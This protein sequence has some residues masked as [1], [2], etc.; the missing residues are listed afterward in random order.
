MEY[1]DLYLEKYMG[2]LRFANNFQYLYILY[3]TTVVDDFLTIEET[4]WI[5]QNE[6]VIEKKNQLSTS[7]SKIRFAIDLPE[8]IRTKLQLPSGPSIPITWI[9]GDSLSHIDVGERIFSETVLVYVAGSANEGT[10]VLGDDRYE[11]K[12]NR[13]FRFPKGTEHHTEGSNGEPRLLIG[14]MSETGFQVGSPGILYFNSY[15]DVYPN[16]IYNNIIYTDY[17]NYPNNG[18]VSTSTTFPDSTFIPPPFSGA[19]LVSWAGKT[20]DGLGGYVDVSY[21]PGDVWI[22]TGNSSYLYPIWSEPSR[23]MC[24][25]EGTQI[26]CLD[27]QDNQEKYLPIQDLRK[28]VLVKTS[29]NGY[30]PIKLIGH[31]KIYNPANSLRFKNRLYRCKKEKYPELFEDLIITGCHSILVSDLT[32]KER[33][34]TIELMEHTYVT[35]HKYRLIACVDERADTFEEQGVFPIW[36][37]ALENEYIRGNYGVYANGLLVETSSIRMMSEYSGME[38][39]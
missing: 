11:I 4:N 38:L 37:F 39:V 1:L 12:P 17:Y 2:N 32:Q 21:N 35:E 20:T 7:V 19:T 15:D 22:N 23:V 3:M 31:S 33:E 10:L 6:N 27:S 30:K 13:Y 14:P 18:I 34:D 25:K 24:F 5:I 16:I 9:S 26:L 8:S 28:G 36:H 29:E